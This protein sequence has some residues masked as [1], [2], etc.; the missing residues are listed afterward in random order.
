MNSPASVRIDK[1]LWAVRL[2]KTR[3]LAAETCAA[4]KV[5]IAEQNVKPARNVHIGDVITAVCG[6]MTKT[7]KVL[8][9]IENRVGAK[10]VKFFLEDLTPA[11]EYEKP[12]EK[13][14]TAIGFRPKGEGRPTKKDRRSLKIFFEGN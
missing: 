9:L 11:S 5:K 12:R 6:E 14:F 4:G 13:N 2:Y 7:V 10:L 8:G 3:T 1:W